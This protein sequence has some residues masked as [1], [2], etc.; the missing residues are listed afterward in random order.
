MIP[1]LVTEHKVCLTG[2]GQ[3]RDLVQD[4]VHPETLDVVFH[5]ALILI[6]ASVLRGREFDIDLL[7]RSELEGLQES[8]VGVVEVWAFFL[9]PCALFGGDADIGELWRKPCEN[10]CAYNTR[11]NPLEENITHSP[12]APGAICVRRGATSCVGFDS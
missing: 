7:G 12:S 1:V 9:Q 6:A 8:E 2:Q 11:N 10:A 5:D 3:Q 4:R